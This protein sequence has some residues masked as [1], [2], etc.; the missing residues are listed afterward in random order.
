MDFKG[1]LPSNNR[2]LN[3]LNI[4][5][6]Y[7]RFPFV[8]PCLD[9]TAA[10]VI[11]ALQTIF[12]MFGY[13]SYIHND[14]GSSFMSQELQQY[15]QAVGIAMNRT[16]SH[17][18][19][20]NGQ[21]EREN[22]RACRHPAVGRRVLGP[23]AEVTQF[24]LGDRACRHP[25]VG[26][27]VLGP[28]AEVTQ[29]Q[30]GDRACRHPAVGRRV[31]GPRAEVTQFQLGD[32][33][34]RGRGESFR[35]AQSVRPT[36]R[37]FIYYF[38]YISCCA[39][40][41]RMS[42]ANSFALTIWLVDGS[43]VTV[44]ARPSD[45]VEDVKVSVIGEIER[46]TS[47]RG[48]WTPEGVNLFSRQLPLADDDTVAECGLGPESVVVQ[49]TKTP[50]GSGTID[51][52]I[53]GKFPQGTSADWN[54][55][56][57]FEIN[58]SESQSP[59]ES[60]NIFDE[61]GCHRVKS[62]DICGLKDEETKWRVIE[63]HISKHDIHFRIFLPDEGFYECSI[64][65]LRWEIKRAV[66]ITYRYC[67]WNEY[68]PI[69]LIKKSEFC[70]PLFNIVAEDNIVKAIHLP[71]FICL[72]DTDRMIENTF[73]VFYVRGRSYTVQ[74][75][76][77][78]HQTCVELQMPTFS[79]LGVIIDRNSW[80][81]CH[82][83]ALIYQTQYTDA[84]E[85]HIYAVPDD[86]AIMQAVHK[87]ESE[88]K[89]IKH[90]SQIKSLY[91]GRKYS[92]IS[93]SE[94]YIAPDEMKFCY[95]DMESK[96]PFYKVVIS[97]EVSSFELKLTKRKKNVPLWQI[98]LRFQN[99]KVLCQEDSDEDVRQRKGMLPFKKE[100][101]PSTSGVRL[102]VSDSNVNVS[103]SDESIQKFHSDTEIQP[104]TAS[105]LPPDE[106]ETL[107]KKDADALPDS[108]LQ[109]SEEMERSATDVHV[110]AKPS[111][112]S[113]DEEKAELA[114]FGPSHTVADAG[115]D[116]YE[117]SEYLTVL[118]FAK[119]DLIG[120][121]HHLQAK[122]SDYA[123]YPVILTPPKIKTPEE[124]L[125]H[126]IIDPED[127][128]ECLTSLGSCCDQ[129][130]ILDA[131]NFHG[132]ATEV[133]TFQRQQAILD[134]D[135]IC[136]DATEKA[137]QKG[138]GS[139]TDTLQEEFLSIQKVIQALGK[140]SSVLCDK[141]TQT[142]KCSRS[143]KGKQK[144]VFCSLSTQTEVIFSDEDLQSHF[145]LHGSIATQ[146]EQNDRHCSKQELQ[147]RDIKDLVDSKQ[148]EMFSSAPDMQHIEQGNTASPNRDSQTT[149]VK[150]TGSDTEMH[151]RD[152]PVLIDASVQTQE[153]GSPDN[154]SGVG[155]FRAETVGDAQEGKTTSSNN[156]LDKEPVQLSNAT[157]Q[158]LDSG[159]KEVSQSDASL[160]TEEMQGV[161]L[162]SDKETVQEY[163]G[164]KQ[165]NCL[166]TDIQNLPLNKCGLLDLIYF[167]KDKCPCK[168]PKV[169]KEKVKWITIT[170]NI[171]ENGNKKFGISLPEKGCYE[172]AITKLRWITKSQVTL[173]YE[174]CS[175]NE[176]I[177][178]VQRECWIIGSSLFNITLQNGSVDA[179]YLPHFICETGSRDAIYSA[180]YNIAC[181]RNNIFFLENP[182][183]VTLSHAILRN[184]SL[185]IKG[186]I[187]YQVCQVAVHAIILIYQTLRVDSS[188]FHLYVL[189][190]DAALIQAIDL[191][192]K[193]LK[194]L[195]IQ[196]PPQ[197]I[198]LSY[199]KKYKLTSFANV[200]IIPSDIKF[201]YFR[202]NQKLPFYE[203]NC[204]E[205]NYNIK[206][207]LTE[208]NKITVLWEL[209]IKP[210]MFKK[211]KKG[212]DFVKRHKKEIICCLKMTP[213][214]WSYLRTKS[215]ISKDEEREVS[216]HITEMQQNR[217]L[218]QLIMKRGEEAEAEEELYN[219]LVE[220]DPY[221]VTS[222][223][224]NYSDKL[225][226]NCLRQWS[227][228]SL[229]EYSL[230]TNE[231]NNK[232]GRTWLAHLV[233]IF[234]GLIAGYLLGYNFS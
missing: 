208:K 155:T 209:L 47:H 167:E 141:G 149:A 28:R 70:G 122:D 46:S 218:I 229:Q 17:N 138:L 96:Q 159:E 16:T 82:S 38:L 227:S 175:W 33:D 131:K 139:F 158:T 219:A 151:R 51:Y 204:T 199:G 205:K 65:G 196:R 185:A 3:F 222:V 27:R 198:A 123:N 55:L 56:V 23:R 34:G 43:R 223:E 184:Q 230:S 9:M 41:S 57:E 77:E 129:Q 108:S 220:N 1:P 154:D 177:S 86:F 12:T 67:S 119:F 97:E 174:Y 176:Y 128:C 221:F 76:S 112:S 81:S 79:L 90:P 114:R 226:N 19:R 15:L 157:V 150:S 25:A 75:P 194:S 189:P 180:V 127:V 225:C 32:R 78:V 142:E 130:D 48:R 6:E 35:A 49:Q 201:C 102:S 152:D 182:S 110:A 166:Q 8:I 202:F 212:M 206:L 178:D 124:T 26:R 44:K 146:T 115:L 104:D 195:K 162:D 84:A 186:V 98:L 143:S 94:V 52:T 172:C 211:M 101:L 2:N 173:T 13:P 5:D 216:S 62:C 192:E 134:P 63:P 22:D 37:C 144:R 91:F 24:Q 191:Q 163:C 133:S 153:T 39:I 45:T 210:D 213:P 171:R 64:T 107:E 69:I 103:S 224:C 72:K 232:N 197:I 10:T 165:E 61:L 188:N 193:E 140:E 120:S 132:H 54:P 42:E 58:T 87:Q 187:L 145:K 40:F 168:M 31:L 179:V 95:T 88:S 170:P 92:L 113:T 126:Y 203:V 4:V 183:E 118:T 147:A 66:T 53:A 14:R 85:L 181:F 74:K 73:A 215:V 109:L 93:S 18:P 100:S 111:D 207:S 217:A 231:F 160:Q 89:L 117:A 106:M 68:A 20:R 80:F 233:C 83:Q 234:S 214:I 137:L 60:T 59:S 105:E 30:L 121:C 190:N 125:C 71:H 169:K 99:G 148:G 164:L 21:V 200:T 228:A 116:F 11:K 135:D 36:V 50:D 156:Q 29:F 161:Q 136:S 7:S